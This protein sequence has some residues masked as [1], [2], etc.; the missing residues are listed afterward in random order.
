LTIAR[1]IIFSKEGGI[2]PKSDDNIGPN[3]QELLCNPQA[4]KFYGASSLTRIELN[5]NSITK[6]HLKKY[7][8]IW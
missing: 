5:Y 1:H 6:S 2:F 8:N 7:T 4:Y 3:K